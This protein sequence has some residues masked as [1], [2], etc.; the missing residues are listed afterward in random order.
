MKKN[1][2]I[3]ISKR[4]MVLL[5]CCSLVSGACFNKYKVTANAA[6]M[7]ATLGSYAAYEICLYIG[8]L[9]LTTSGMACVYDNRDKIA[10]L[11]KDFIDSMNLDEVSGWLLSKVN[12]TGQSYVYGTEA[13]Q[14]IQE[15]EFTV[16]QGGGNMPEN[17]N[18]ND[19]DGDIDADD[20][21]KELE[22]MGLWLTSSF[23]DFI[24]DLIEPLH[25]QYESEP[26]ESILFNYFGSSDYSFDGS[27]SPDSS[28]YYYYNFY[29][30]TWTTSYVQQMTEKR[31]VKEYKTNDKICGYLYERVSNTTYPT[32]EVIVMKQGTSVKLPYYSCFYNLDGSLNRSLNSSTWIFPYTVYHANF[33]VFATEQ[34]AKDYLDSGVLEGCSN[35]SKTY[36]IADWLQEHWGSALTQLNTGIRSLNDN[37]LIVGEAANQALINQ[38]NGLGYIEDLGNRIAT[39]APLALPDSIADPEYYPAGSSVP[40]LAPEELPWNVPVVSPDSGQTPGTDSTPESGEDVVIGD[41]AIDLRKLFPFCIPFD[42]IALLRVLDAEPEAPRFEVP[43]VVPSVGIDEMYVIDLSMFDDVMEVIRLFELVGFVIGLMLLTGKVIKW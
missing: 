9:L 38:S 15:M 16:I 1:R 42:F 29:S 14:E 40:E 31:S 27:L 5:L 23:A 8:G 28:G 12:T 2:F 34:Q 36:Q 35:V 33:P 24:S 25:E 20:R 6:A 13:L 43:F 11:G 17:N 7:T 41:Y 3:R 18:D 22:H 32:S 10:E 26:L 37:M 4:V 19:D 30:E 21:T 39:T